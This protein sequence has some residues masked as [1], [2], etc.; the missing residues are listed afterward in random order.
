M[1]KKKEVKDIVRTNNEDKI[2]KYVKVSNYY[3]YDKD[4]F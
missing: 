1:Y 3:D 4:K 2:F